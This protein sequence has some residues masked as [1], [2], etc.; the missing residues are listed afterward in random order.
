[1]STQKQ[2]EALFKNSM[3]YYQAMDILDEVRAGANYPLP[4][5]NK[6]L[7][8]TGDLN[9]HGIFERFRSERM[10]KKIQKENQRLGLE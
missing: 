9:E 10:E 3:N 1:M 2:P 8:L 5:I 7:E 6:A 4:I